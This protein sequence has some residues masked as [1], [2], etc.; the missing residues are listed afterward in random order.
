M[1]DRPSSADQTAT[2]IERYAWA[3][4]ATMFAIPIPGADMAA[5]F[6]V[7]GLM[8]REIARAHGEELSPR[9]GVRLASQLFK[10]AV[11]TGF[12]WVGSA[13]LAAEILKL[14][15][16]AGTLAAYAV[17]AG[18]AAAGTRRITAAVGAAAAEYFASGKDS[19]PRTF[20]EHLDVVGKDPA[21]WRSAAALLRPKHR[22][23]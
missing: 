15:P 12:V 22:G 17:D 20:R 13:T 21:F 11:L 23:K 16:V 5:T 9:D 4:A 19:G 2:I 18:V 7:W 6:A 8:I 10:N 3:A 1:P 14:I